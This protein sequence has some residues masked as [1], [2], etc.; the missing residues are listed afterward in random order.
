MI[1]II[2]AKI[3]H[4]RLSIISDMYLDAVTEDIAQHHIQ[5]HLEHF[6][7]HVP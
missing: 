6:S 1:E 3:A 7:K 4:P 2:N 5:D